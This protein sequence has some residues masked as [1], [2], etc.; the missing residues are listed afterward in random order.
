MLKYLLPK[1]PFITVKL[2]V[3]VRKQLFL[4]LIVVNITLRAFNF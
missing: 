1:V 3:N 2:L 4:K